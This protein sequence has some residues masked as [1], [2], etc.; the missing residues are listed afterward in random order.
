MAKRLS[1]PQLMERTQV[2]RAIIGLMIN[3]LNVRLRKIA[4]RFGVA[5]AA[6]MALTRGEIVPLSLPASVAA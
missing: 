5:G 3:A 4:S 6:T 2:R 1:L